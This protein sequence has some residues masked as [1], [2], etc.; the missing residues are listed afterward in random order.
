M[1]ENSPER[2]SRAAASEPDATYPGTSPMK[3]GRSRMRS[4]AV[5]SCVSVSHGRGA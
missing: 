2:A 4:G 3:T 5:W 1:T